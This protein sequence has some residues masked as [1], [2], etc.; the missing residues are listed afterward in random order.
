MTGHLVF[1]TIH[2]YLDE[3]PDD[4]ETEEID[5]WPCWQT[6]DHDCENEKLTIIKRSFIDD[7][8]KLRENML[9]TWEW[10]SC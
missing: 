9:A 10:Q 6:N 7:I 8:R 2:D 5:M 3:L 4:Y 1:Q